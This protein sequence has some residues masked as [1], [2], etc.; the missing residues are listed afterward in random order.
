MDSAGGCL[1]S[2][3]LWSCSFSIPCPQMLLS[4]LSSRHLGEWPWGWGQ[5]ECQR[6]S[7]FVP[8]LL[9]L[10]RAAA[11]RGV[12][13]AAARVRPR[14]G[15][16]G[17]PVPVPRGPWHPS[18]SLAMWMSWQKGDLLHSAWVCSGKGGEDAAPCEQGRHWA[19]GAETQIL[20]AGDGQGGSQPH[21]HTH[22]VGHRWGRMSILLI[23]TW[24]HVPRAD[25]VAPQSKG[26]GGG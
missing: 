18:A 26:P 24:S 13:R 1:A 5:R 6:G 23:S 8:C 12:C 19:K 11:G 14:M 9:P 17:V 15:S 10:V 25:P 4:P 22:S 2:H 16:G 20:S 21:T 3:S 7:M